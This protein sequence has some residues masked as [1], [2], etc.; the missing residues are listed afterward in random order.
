MYIMLLESLVLVLPTRI[1]P[2]SGVTIGFNITE[3][4]VNENAGSV[5]AIVS[6][7]S[8][9]LARAVSVRVSTSDN[10]AS[11]RIK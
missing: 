11:E 4:S 5:S 1:I 9:T 6:V 10:S 8:G 3:Y 7:L 2:I